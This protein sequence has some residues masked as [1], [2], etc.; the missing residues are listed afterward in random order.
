[1]KLF[2]ELMK[3]WNVYQ[4]KKKQH[5]QQMRKSNDLKLWTEITYCS[6]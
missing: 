5:T 6:D 1:M 2:L 4:N 3:A